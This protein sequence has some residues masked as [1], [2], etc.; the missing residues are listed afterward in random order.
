M[1]LWN[2]EQWKHSMQSMNIYVYKLILF[3]NK[4]PDCLPSCNPGCLPGCLQNYHNSLSTT[5]SWMIFSSDS[6]KNFPTA[7]KMG[8]CVLLLLKVELQIL[9][10]YVPENILQMMILVKRQ[11]FTDKGVTY[12]FVAFKLSLSG[13]LVA[14]FFV[15]FIMSKSRGS[16]P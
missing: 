3:G 12:M 5:V 2:N 6:V 9:H 16:P 7:K 13:T 1:K 10:R 14:I 4:Y 11:I 8:Q 15:Y